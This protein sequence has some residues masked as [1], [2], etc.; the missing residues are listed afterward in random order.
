[1]HSFSAHEEEG[2]NLISWKTGASTTVGFRA[3]RTVRHSEVVMNNTDG[4]M[5]K[6]SCSNC[7]LKSKFSWFSWNNPPSPVEKGILRPWMRRRR[8]SA[9]VSLA[10]EALSNCQCL[11]AGQ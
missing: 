1:M 7:T 6:N 3:C 9:S 2:T 5:E 11:R 10:A 8:L 4:I